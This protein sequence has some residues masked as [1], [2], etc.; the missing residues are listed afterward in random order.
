[1][2]ADHA[3]HVLAVL[4]VAGERAELTGHLGRGGVRLAGQDRR[5][6]SRDRAALFGVVGQAHRHQQ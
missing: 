4:A 3:Q 6:S 1:M 5:Q 2:V